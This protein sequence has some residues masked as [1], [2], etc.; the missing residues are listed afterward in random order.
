VKPTVTA[1]VGSLAANLISVLVAFGVTLSNVQQ[2]ALLALVGSITTIATVLVAWVQTHRIRAL[3][4]IATNQDLHPAIAGAAV[5]QL[6]GQK[7]TD[8]A[9]PKATP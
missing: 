2:V 9:I 3:A 5:T 7:A 4:A 1:L 6:L 8:T